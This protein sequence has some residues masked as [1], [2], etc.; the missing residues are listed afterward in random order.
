M[1]IQNLSAEQFCDWFVGGVQAMCGDPEK[2][3]SRAFE[4]VASIGHSRE[5]DWVYE[6]TQVIKPLAAR[7]SCV[8][9]L[10]RGI[11][12]LAQEVNDSNYTSLDTAMIIADDTKCINVSTIRSV[13]EKLINKDLEPNVRTHLISRCGLCTFNT[14]V[15][16][17]EDA[18]P[19]LMAILKT[20][21]FPVV[22]K[23]RERVIEFGI[24]PSEITG[25]DAPLGFQLGPRVQ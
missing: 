10:R 18:K 11:I 8:L 22:D 21:N 23:L 16:E 6:V 1:L 2:D 24:D 7:E 17:R 25:A 4:P 15:G 9:G 12:I 13:F 14:N 3:L 20:L 19:L 5:F